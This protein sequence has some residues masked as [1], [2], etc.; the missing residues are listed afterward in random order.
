M[1]DN[2]GA[3]SKSEKLVIGIGIVAVLLCV[4]AGL[5]WALRQAEWITV[6]HS[7][8]PDPFGN[9]HKEWLDG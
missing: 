3:P 6:S 4:Y 1:A 2:K 9:K 8:P 7:F 5:Y